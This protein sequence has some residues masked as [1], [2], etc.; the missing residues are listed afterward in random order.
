MTL[1]VDG[2]QA[3]VVLIIRDNG[4]GIAPEEQLRIFDRFYRGRAARNYKVPGTG[5]GLAICK[6]IVTRLGGRITVESW[7][8]HGSAFCVW[9]RVAAESSPSA[10]L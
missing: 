4:P 10:T 6:E 9:L 5:L 1:G 7:P 8:E 3:W 2:G